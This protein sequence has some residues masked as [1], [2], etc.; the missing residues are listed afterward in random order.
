MRILLRHALFAWL[1][2]PLISCER[3]GGGQSRDS[4]S[5]APLV[6]GDSSAPA[7]V[8]SGWN[9]D[10]GPTL[11]VAGDAP[12]VAQVIFPEVTDST[13]GDT[14]LMDLAPVSGA[15]V[16]LF[17]HKGRIGTAMVA[18]PD[19]TSQADS[20]DESC[21]DWP[22]VRLRSERGSRAGTWTA[23]LL[24]GHARPIALDSIEGL[25]KADSSRLSA[26]VARLS[27]SIPDD[28]ARAFRGLPYSVRTVRRFRA[29]PGVD[30]LASEVSRR[31]N[32]E[33]NPR[34]EQVFFVAERDSGQSGGPWKIAFAQRASGH[35]GSVESH[36][37][38]AAVSIGAARRP[39]LILSRYLGDGM[40][41]A[42]LER[43]GP[44]QWRLRW[45]SATSGC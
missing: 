17:S 27:G 45:V 41:Y 29:V 11:L 5:P 9:A 8:N 28:T 26:E 23:A 24:A 37:V 16:E 4:A 18:G 3:S 33:A 40:S 20:S 6:N 30:A 15:T 7:S 12:D 34:E 1:A 38:L 2:L 44:R 32:Q 25:S 14:T 10:A 21:D 35:E 42:F 19:T 22:M 43:V 39:T 31:I 13:L 36:D